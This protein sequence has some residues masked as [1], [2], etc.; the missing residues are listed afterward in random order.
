[1]IGTA[2]TY[3]ESSPSNPNEAETYF[4]EFLSYVNSDIRTW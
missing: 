4:D 3:D 1:M 2:E